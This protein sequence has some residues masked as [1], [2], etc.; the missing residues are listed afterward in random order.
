ML[1]SNGDTAGYE[2]GALPLS[3]TTMMMLS[4]TMST[5]FGIWDT[6]QL[7][8]DQYMLS[9]WLPTRNIAYTVEQKASLQLC[10]YESYTT[11][12]S[13][14]GNV[15]EAPHQ[16]LHVMIYPS[17][18]TTAHDIDWL[19]ILSRPGDNRLAPNKDNPSML[20]SNTTVKCLPH[21]IR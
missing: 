16:D 8:V 3:I 21:D 17:G 9:L 11:T 10:C 15:N 19:E 4:I 20:F 12:S 7:A 1:T 14:E 2:S 13:F 6:F 18:K 5:I